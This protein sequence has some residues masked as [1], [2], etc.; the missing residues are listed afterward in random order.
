[1]TAASR[2]VAGIL[3]IIVPTVVMGGASVLTLLVND[4]EYGES[5]LRQDLRRA[6]HAHGVVL[7]VLSLIALRYGDDAA[8]AVRTRWFV[9][10]ASRPPPSCCRW[11]SSSSCSIQTQPSPMPRSTW[12]TSA[13]CCPWP[14]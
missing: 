5:A 11:G 1:M 12:P 7:L 2:R 3:L 10:L 8:V 14:R 4:A 13:Q 9:R 6:G